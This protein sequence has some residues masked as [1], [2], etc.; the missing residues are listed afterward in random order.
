M[1]LIHIPFPPNIKIDNIVVINITTKPL[2]IDIKP[3]SL[4]LSMEDS[5]PDVTTLN[6]IKAN[7]IENTLNAFF[8][9]SNSSKLLLSINI[10]TIK[11]LKNTQVAK[12]AV[13]KKVTTFKDVFNKNFTDS[14]SPFPL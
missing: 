14:I 4:D 11:S 1:A 3:A 10:N 13:E 7:D 12:I 5:T 6:P 2:P 9:Y 8:V